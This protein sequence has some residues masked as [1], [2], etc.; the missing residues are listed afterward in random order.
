MPFVSSAEDLSEVF[1]QLFDSMQEGFAIHEIIC[2]EAGDPADYRVID[3][4]P[5][6]EELTGIKRELIVG[7][8]VKDVM[9]ATET[10]W[11]QRYGNVALTGE[12]ARLEAF[13]EA[14][15]RHYSVYTYSPGPKLFATL[16]SDVTDRV[17]AA[18]SL[19]EAN[20]S[21]EEKVRL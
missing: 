5:A 17:R 16:F 21:L 9:P 4:N 8:T 15:G 7:K 1:R 2:D 18:D 10:Y 12:P 14:I 3:V 13:A 20:E 19:R 11:I 6:F